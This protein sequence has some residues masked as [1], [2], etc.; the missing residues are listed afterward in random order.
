[1]NIVAI[2]PGTTQSA[3]VQLIDGEITAHEI[4]DNHAVLC[5]LLGA[6]NR[7]E[8]SLA[9]EMVA[10][11]GMPVGKDVFETVLWIGRF[12]QAWA[13]TYQ[14]IYRKDVKMFLCGST[15]AKDSNIRQAI[16]DL[17][18]AT[19]GGKTPQVGTKKQPGPLFGFKADMWAALGVALT[20]QAT[21]EGKYKT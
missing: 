10:S 1:M 15:R 6:G 19:G 4:S 14:K 12:I 9:I 5:G 21:R 7:E 3:V 13:S 20:Y 8:Y 11:Y 16:L 2:D 18:P 17:Y